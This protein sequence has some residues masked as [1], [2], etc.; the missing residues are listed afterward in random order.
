MIKTVSDRHLPQENNATGIQFR[1]Q[2]LR[3]AIQ[4]AIALVMVAPT[5]AVENPAQ[6]QSLRMLE[7]VVVT[8]QRREQRLEEV[9]L[10]IVPLRAEDLERAG[11]TNMHNL[12]EITPGV[13]INHAGA[14]S[15]PAIRGVS[16]LTTGNG[17]ENNVA[18][19]VDGFYEPNNNIIAMDLANL[20]GIEVL[21]GPQ[22]TLYGRNATGG[23]ILLNTLAPSD[24]FTG[25]LSATYGRFDDRRINGFLSG[26]ISD[27]VRYS[28]S[29]YFRKMDGYIELSD[30]DRPGRGSGKYVPTEHRSVRA[31]LEVDLTENL[32]ATLGYNYTFVDERRG[33][34]FTPFEYVA[35]TVAAPPARALDRDMT[36]YNSRTEQPV[37]IHQGTLKLEWATGM[38]TL[39][40]YTGFSSASPDS[41]F[42][43]DGTYVDQLRAVS[44][45]EQDTFQQAVDFNLDVW[46]DWNIV[47][48]GLYYKDE[49]H[50][51]FQ[52]LFAG[53]L[54]QRLDTSL[55]TEAIALYLDATY[56]VT[57]KLSVNFGGRYSYEEMTAF[58]HSVAGN[59][60]EIFAPT[61]KSEDFDQF[62]P[63][64]SVRYELAERTNIYA[65]YSKGFRSGTFSLSGAPTPALWQ[66]LDAEI[67]D[68]F[69]VGLKVVRPR[70]RFDVAAFYYD[71][72]D[73]HVSTTQ[74]APG[75]GGALVT[76][77]ENADE[78]EIYGVD[79][80]VEISLS[81]ELTLRMGAAW[82]EAEYTKFPNASGIGLNID[83]GLNVSNQEQDWS[84]QEMARAPNFSGNLGLTY[85]TPLVGGAGGHLML[86]G[87]VS[88]SDSYV[89]NNP[90]VYGPMAGALADKQRYRQSATTLVSATATWTDPSERYR[91]R[92]FG[93]N[94]TNEEYFT[95]HTG[96]GDGDR[97]NFEQPRSYG[98]QVSYQF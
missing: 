50:L 43:I 32:V 71:Y 86:S 70:Y 7:E 2:R 94:L 45:A 64:V 76:V 36:S 20:A 18:L 63:R 33:I 26:P 78:A 82:L 67:I 98:V 96:G 74:P 13:Q 95:V 6:P 73:L 25:N 93:T 83:T 66:P 91:V 35:P 85:E 34:L 29:A 62:T 48:G 8:A 72:Q 22:G 23:A 38:G 77:F 87:N 44:R 60:F 84:G 4:G 79:G 31:K 3:T 68:A 88:Y 28:V 21:K 39:S 37:S 49:Y 92:L 56:D 41:D 97:G 40:S 55:D 47:L 11:V 1:H 52:A 10:S 58:H 90:S 14:F 5:W 17:V 51:D 46:D 65:T 75:G 80:Q 42:D 61:K 54:A 53:N 16:S 24:T 30:P 81:D 59:G 12:G 15:Q 19:Y 9:P 27:R 89:V 57:D 69:E